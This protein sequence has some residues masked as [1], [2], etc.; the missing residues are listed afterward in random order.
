MVNFGG[1]QAVNKI[2]IFKFVETNKNVK[3]IITLLA[4]SFLKIDANEK[5][6]KYGGAEF[7]RNL[8]V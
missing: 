6:S 8:M 1:L 7:K 2:D 5:K 3:Q 4:I